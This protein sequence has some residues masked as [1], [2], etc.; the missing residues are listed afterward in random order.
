[1]KTDARRPALLL[2]LLVAMLALAACG[3]ESAEEEPAATTEAPAATE[4]APPATTEEA[5]PAATE[6]AP[7]ATT[8]EA[9]PTPAS[10]KVALDWFPNPD[11]VSLYSA[12]DN[13]LFEEQALDVS[14]EVPSDVTAGLKLVATGEFDLSIYYQG[15]MFYAALEGLPVIGVGALIPQPLNSLIAPAGSKVT[16]LDTIAGATIAETGGPFIAAIFKTMQDELGLAKDDFKTVNV[17]YDLLPAVLTGKADAMIGA[18]ANIEG[19]VLKLETGADPTVITLDQLGVPTFDELLI[20]ANSE[21]LQSD[22]AYADAVAR[23]VSAVAAGQVAAQAD[24]PGSIESMETN[25]EYKPEEIELMVPTTLEL[26]NSPSGLA[27]LCFD[28]AAWDAFGQ[29]MVENA[30]IETPVDVSTIATNDYN[31]G[32]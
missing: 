7:P 29:W 12:L 32:C 27:P 22:A 30:L 5:P 20:V 15:D 31:A 24:A 2:A 21:R 18:Y 3:G 10:L 26:L 28:L 4:E 17:G 14:F 6:E 9:P 1:M 19:N 13:G 16:G 11:H 25:T 8:E 23:F